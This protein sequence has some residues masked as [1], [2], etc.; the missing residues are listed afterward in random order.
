MPGQPLEI[1]PVFLENLFPFEH[2]GAE[3]KLSCIGFILHFQIVLAKAQQDE[4][5]VCLYDIVAFAEKL[6]RLAVVPHHEMG[7]TD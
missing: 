1:F 7:V 2:I 4:R 3:K 5:I 6:Q